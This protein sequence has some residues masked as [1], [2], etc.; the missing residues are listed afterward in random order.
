MFLAGAK[1]KKS[2]Q[3]QGS[4]VYPVTLRKKI[5]PAPFLSTYVI[6]FCELRMFY[7]CP[8]K[9]KQNVL[10]HK[11]GRVHQTTKQLRTPHPPS[12]IHRPVKSAGGGYR[13][14][15]PYLVADSNGLKSQFNG[16][17]NLSTLKRLIGKNPSLRLG[18]G[19]SKICLFLP[20]TLGKWSSLT[21]IRLKW[22]GSTTN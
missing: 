19:N 15:E 1:R 11:N 13:Y 21:S 2:E 9:K 14:D 22:V 17:C 10:K 20:R 8:T 3:S 6:L 4:R 18:G 16:R 7:P 5:S 12:T